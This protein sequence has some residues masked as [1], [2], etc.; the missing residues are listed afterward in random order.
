MALQPNLRALIIAGRADAPHTL[1]IFRARSMLT[2]C[3]LSPDR[4]S[5][6]HSGLRV[7]V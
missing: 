2:R 3:A 6:L 5:G 4:S 7:P 1:D